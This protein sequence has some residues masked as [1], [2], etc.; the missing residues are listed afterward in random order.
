MKEKTLNQIMVLVEYHHQLS[1]MYFSSGIND[2]GEKHYRRYS[3]LSL[4]V[5]RCMRSIYCLCP[6]D[7]KNN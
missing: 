6:S 4:I 2:L 1:S 7:F 5:R 3:N